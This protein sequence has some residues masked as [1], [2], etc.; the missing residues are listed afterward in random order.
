MEG[1]VHPRQDVDR[2]PIRRDQ[3]AGDPTV[4]VVDVPEARDVALEAGQIFEIGGGRDEEGVDPPLAQLLA[5][6]GATLGIFLFGDSGCLASCGSFW[7]V[8]LRVA[9]EAGGSAVRAEA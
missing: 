1:D 3:G 8:G 9:E 5:E 2:L 4:R 6:L 7:V